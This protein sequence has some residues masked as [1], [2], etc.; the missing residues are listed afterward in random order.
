MAGG[1]AGKIL[2]LNMTNGTSSTLNTSDY[3]DK[4]V[5]GRL[6]G[7]AVFWD[8]VSKDYITDMAG[9]T[10]HEPENVLCITSGPLQGTLAPNGGRCEI[11]GI[12]PEGYPRPVFSRSNAGGRFSAMLKFAGYD[13]IAITGKA[14]SPVWVNIVDDK[15]T[16]EDAEGVWGLDCYEAQEEIYRR[17]RAGT[18]FGAWQVTGYRPDEEYSSQIPAVIT[19]GPAGENL[20]KL[21]CLIHDGGKGF[22]QGGFG[23]VFGSKN[24]KAISV[25]G[26]GSVDVADPEKLLATRLWYKAYSPAGGSGGRYNTYPW[27]SNHFGRALNCFACDRGCWMQPDNPVG[28]RMASGSGCVEGYYNNNQTFDKASWMGNIL[29]YETDFGRFAVNYSPDPDGNWLENGGFKNATLLD[30]NGADHVRPASYMNRY[31][32]NAYTMGTGGLAWL[33]SLYK[34]GLLGPGKAINTDLDFSR[35]GEPDLAVELLR[36]IAY[37]EE[38]GD[39]LAEGMTRAA[40]KWGVLEEDLASGVLP[41]IYNIGESHWGIYVDWAY[42]SLFADNR[43]INFHSTSTVLGNSES[44]PIEW[45]AQRAGEVMWPWD[46]DPT[47]CDRSPDGVYSLGMARCV[48]WMVRYSAFYRD[49]AMMCCWNM[50]PV[51]FSNL[52]EDGYGLN[53][54]YEEDF[55][56]SITGRDISYPEGLGTYGRRSLNLQRAISVLGGKHRDEDYFPPYP[57]YTS[58]VYTEGQPYLQNNKFGGHTPST[59]PWYHPED[60]TWTMEQSGFALDRDRMDDFKSIFYDLEGWDTT[61]GGPTRATLEG[62]DLG[63]VADELASRGKLGA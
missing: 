60:G 9:K 51:F 22:G 61:T 39:D 52:T 29:G 18:K 26:S 36:R 59:S 1:H 5:G 53:P 30:P 50:G 40:E 23:G 19:C 57:P 10:G 44:R 6:M 31:G 12:A 37:R 34:R 33:H 35:M 41:A 27:S 58:Y 17:V 45:R 7:N 24:L 56:N 42:A 55:L 14:E 28:P 47:V 20:V 43:D 54:R 4:F 46:P 15:V 11:V 2:V 38:I 21:A 16:F 62:L 63:Y 8:L 3:A 25:L 32:L 48:S 49:S 13:I